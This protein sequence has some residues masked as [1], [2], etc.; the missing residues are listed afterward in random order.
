MNGV[1]H[2]YIDRFL[3]VYIDDIL[4]Y[5]RKREEHLQHIRCVLERL[6]KHKL[7]VSPKK[8]SFMA[9]ET[10]FLGL[11]VSCEG[12]SVHPCSELLQMHDF[13]AHPHI[14]IRVLSFGLKS[15]KDFR[16]HFLDL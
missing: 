2:D 15:T 1:L 14:S 5:S 9:T 3:V 6:R 8:C 16:R 4:I 10:E 13:T 11:R 12:L 7:Y